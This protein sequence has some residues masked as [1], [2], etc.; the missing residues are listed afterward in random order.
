MSFFDVGGQANG[1]IFDHGEPDGQLFY[2]FKLCLCLIQRHFCTVVGISGGVGT[3]SVIFYQWDFCSH[4]ASGFDPDGVFH[5]YSIGNLLN[6]SDADFHICLLKSRICSPEGFVNLCLDILC[7]IDKVH[8]FSDQNVSFFVHQLKSL[9][10][11]SKGI[12]CKY[13]ISLGGKGIWIQETTSLS[14]LTVS[15]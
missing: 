13:Q 7:L 14:Y 12:F 5:R 4:N 15:L 1:C 10:G 3:L 2:F 9:T 8:H 6:K 11:K